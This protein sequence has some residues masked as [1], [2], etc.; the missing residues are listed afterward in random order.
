MRTAVAVGVLCL[1]TIVHAATLP[2]FAVQ[3][4]STSSGFI[5]SIVVDSRGRIDY[6]TTSGDVV[7][8]DGT[9]STVL[10]HVDTNAVGNSGLLGMALRD[11]DTAIVN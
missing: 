5:S 10:A 8:F 3:Q 7:R 4:V 9:Q 11:D 6:T 1:A 2:G